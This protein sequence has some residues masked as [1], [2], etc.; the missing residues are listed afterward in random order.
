MTYV[1]D[2]FGTDL[3]KDAF[4]WPSLEPVFDAAKKMQAAAKT[5]YPP[6]NIRKTSENTY[7]IE[8]AVAGFQRQELEITLE[9]N[10]LIVHGSHKTEDSPDSF[11]Y[12]GIGLRDFTRMFT[13]AD[14]VEVTNAEMVNGLLRVYLE[15]L[16]P[17]HQKPRRIEVKGD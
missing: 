11:I 1:R 9:G 13:V 3:F 12:R 8:L 10:K 5:N 15:Q 6:F 7:V 16:L 14:H 17:A 2:V 4:A